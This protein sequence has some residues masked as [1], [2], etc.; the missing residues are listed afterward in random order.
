MVFVE[1]LAVRLALESDLEVVEGV[2]RGSHALALVPTHRVRTVL[3]GQCLEDMHGVELA[4]RL[5]GLEPAPHVVLLGDSDRPA[6]VAEA[7]RAGV[8]AW[9]GKDSPVELLLQAIRAV[10][11]GE[12]WLS[13]TMLGPVVQLLL[14]QMRRP[15]SNPLEDL[16]ARELDVLQCMVEGLGQ[17]AIAKRLYVSPNTVRTHRRRTLAKLGV[18]SSLEA[19]AV[20][21]RAGMGLRPGQARLLQSAYEQMTP[22]LDSDGPASA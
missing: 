17:E 11:R 2:S 4:R 5:R 7:L 19:V 18:H 21:R 1:A 6:D 9:V 8:Q 16:T 22:M 12:I 15:T 20:A 3:L 13:S 10:V 14:T